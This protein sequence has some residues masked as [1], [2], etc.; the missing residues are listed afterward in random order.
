MSVMS[1]RLPDEVEQ[2][3]GQLAQSTGRTKSWLANQ[4]IKDY[5][6]REAWQITEVEAALREADAGDFVSE[7]EM[8][9]KFNR[10]GINAG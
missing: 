6:A 10:W 1:V 5:L 8:M 7:K 9:A 3:L 4:A 2:Q